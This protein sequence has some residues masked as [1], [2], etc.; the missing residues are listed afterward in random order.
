MNIVIIQAHIGSTRLPGKVMKLLSGKEVLYHV[1]DRCSKAQSIDKVIIG[2][3]KNPENDV[4][5][6]FCRKNNFECFRGSESDVLDRYYECAVKYNPEIIARVTSDCPLLEPKLIDYWVSNIEK[7]R[8]EFV[9][10][11][12]E[13]F[14]GFGLD[15]FSMAA[16]VKLKRCSSISK[17]KE[18]V[19]GYYLDNPQEFTKKVYPLPEQLQYLYRPYRLTLDTINDYKLIDKLYNLFY[20]NEYVDLEKVMNYLDNNKVDLSINSSIIQKNYY[21]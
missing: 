6:E 11:E 18:H 1:Y 14:L 8:I 21:E 15:V 2:T 4:I 3:S 13:L 7:D 20:K 9:Q 17:Q 16:L 19:I 10:E 12:K 5:E